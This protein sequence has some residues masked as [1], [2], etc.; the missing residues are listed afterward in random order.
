MN[1]TEFTSIINQM[2]IAGGYIQI[3]C[4]ESKYLEFEYGSIIDSLV[5]CDYLKITIEILNSRDSVITQ[6]A[7]NYY[8]SLIKNGNCTDII[9]PAVT[10]NNPLFFGINFNT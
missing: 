8:N 9:V 2:L 5:E 4:S 1:F 3:T 10:N 7:Y 6:H